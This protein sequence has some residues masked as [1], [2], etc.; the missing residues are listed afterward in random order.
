[1]WVAECSIWG[2]QR[3]YASDRVPHLCMSPLTSMPASQVN[4]GRAPSSSIRRPLRSLI[5]KA[6]GGLPF[7]R[8]SLL[9]DMFSWPIPTSPL[10]SLARM[11][12]EG[13]PLTFTPS[14]AH[15]PGCWAVH[16]FQPRWPVREIL[17]GGVRKVRQPGCCDWAAVF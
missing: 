5:Y 14:H 6:Y 2:M 7:F 15:S 13:K 8:C 4:L 16:F 17:A 12:A 9:L 11:Y 1:M 3:R 10:L